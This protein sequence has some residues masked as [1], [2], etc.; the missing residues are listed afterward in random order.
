[1]CFMSKKVN[2]YF[3]PDQN[4][5]VEKSMQESTLETLYGEDC[6][7][8]VCESDNSFITNEEGNSVLIQE[9]F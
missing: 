8:I 6:I 7:Y 2:I 5:D 4:E 9:H 3:S 1:M